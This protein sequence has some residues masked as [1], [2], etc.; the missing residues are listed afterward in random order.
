MR[1]Y[2]CLT[3]WGLFQF[4]L[5]GSVLVVFLEVSVVTGGFNFI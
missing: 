1:L 3:I 2:P 4:D 5:A